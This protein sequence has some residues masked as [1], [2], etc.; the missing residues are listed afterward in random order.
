MKA[1]YRN[2]TVIGSGPNG[3]A[4]AVELARHGLNV[5]VLESQSTFGGGARSAELTLPGFLHDVCSAVHPLASASPFFRGLDLSTHGLEWIQP[6]VPLAHPL[7]DGTAVL[8]HRSIAETSENLDRA[9]AR[10]YRDLMT[11]FV[12]NWEG[13]TADLLGPIRFPSKPLSAA[14][15]G[16]YGLR[17]AKGFAHSRFRGKRIRALF[18]GLAAHSLLP[19]DRWGTTSFGI[20][21]S[22]LGHALGWPIAKGGS[23]K[24]V[25]A[26]RSYLSS[27][28]GSLELNSRVDSLDGRLGPGRVVLCDLTPRGLLR[29]ARN[30]LP[31]R[32]CRKL[33]RFR[34]GNAVFKIDWALSEPIPWNAPEC[35]LAGTVHVGGSIEE[36]VEAEAL[37][38]LGKHPERPFIRLSQPTL[39]DPQRAPDGKHIAW[40]YCHVPLGSTVDLTTRIEDQIERFARGFKDCII[41]KKV[42]PPAELERNNANLVGGSISGGSNDLSQLFLRPTAR[43]YSTPLRN[44]FL[45]SSSTPPGGGVHGMCGFHAAQAALT[46]GG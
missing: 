2:A 30:I 29:I 25:N 44:L 4:A 24:I 16:F 1:E 15:F 40:A 41:A 3:L 26:L 34:M 35:R 22:M 11:P 5:E 32:F 14:R 38:E 7:D 28:G 13:L 12:D 8:L 27:L 23:Q 9:D 21:L 10:S 37:P 43:L 17:T 42:S 33:E 18:A 31:A 36:I 6:P 20:V 45:C 39:F 19:L 46:E